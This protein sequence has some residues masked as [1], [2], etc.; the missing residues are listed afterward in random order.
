MRYPLASRTGSG[1]FWWVLYAQ[2]AWRDLTK[3]QRATLLAMADGQPAKPDV[4]ARLDDKGL[5]EDGAITNLG[6][7]VLRVCADRYLDA[8][9]ELDSGGGCVVVGPVAS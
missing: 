7:W 5:T 6:R 4:A 2:Q 8:T 9:F 3:P 1:L